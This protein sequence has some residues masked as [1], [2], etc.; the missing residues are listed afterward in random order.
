MVFTLCTSGQAVVKAGANVSS[1]IAT[2]GQ[3]LLDLSNESE[4]VISSV[5]AQD[6]VTDFSTFTSEGKLILQRL[7]SNMIAFD[8]VSYDSKGFNST[9]D[10][11]TKLDALQ[12]NIDKDTRLIKD[13]I[14]K[15]YLGVT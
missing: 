3:F 2:S 7:C 10:F 11:E 8:L 4:S 1:T 6:V 9:R 13:D 15:S 12:S 5:A 14:L